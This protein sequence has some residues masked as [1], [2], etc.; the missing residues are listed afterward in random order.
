[1][2]RFRHLHT[3]VRKDSPGIEIGPWRHPVAPKRDGYRTTVIDILDTDQ[4]RGMAR[5]RDVPDCEIP[6]IEEVDIVGDGSNLLDLVRGRGVTE[7]FGWIVSCH[8]FEHLTDPVRFLCDCEELLE[9]VHF[10]LCQGE[11]AV[12]RRGGID[13]NLAIER[14]A[15]GEEFLAV[16][17]R[18]LEL[19]PECFEPARRIVVE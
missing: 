9:P 3:V 10:G 7:R 15:L 19:P 17:L 13:R 11:A 2:E 12:E 4:L 18:G 14:S 1:M 16:L 5:Q 8:N 6:L